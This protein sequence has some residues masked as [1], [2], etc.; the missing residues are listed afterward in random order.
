MAIVDKIDKLSGT[1]VRSKNIEDAVGKL[2]SGGGSGGSGGNGFFVIKTTDYDSEEGTFNHIDKT[3]E[4]IQSAFLSGEVPILYV[5]EYA[6]GSSTDVERVYYFHRTNG[7]MFEF[8]KTGRLSS[9]GAAS[10]DIVS[11]HSDGTIE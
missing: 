7:V 1:N 4:E 3:F 8:I 9:D 11:V 5:T 6:T 2:Q 10:V